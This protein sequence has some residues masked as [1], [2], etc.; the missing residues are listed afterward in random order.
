MFAVQDLLALLDLEQLEV[1]LF[2]GR[3]PETS[4]QRLFDGISPSR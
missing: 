1:N 3:S 2:R 4:W